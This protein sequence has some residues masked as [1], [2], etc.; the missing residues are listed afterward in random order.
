[1][2]KT[3]SFLSLGM[4]S[5]LAACGGGGSDAVAEAPMVIQAV[6]A[7]A[8]ASTLAFSTYAS[9]LAADDRGEPLDVANVTPPTSETEEPIALK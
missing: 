7:T 9:S 3:L 2:K 1:M 4:L 6:P 5:L 8:T